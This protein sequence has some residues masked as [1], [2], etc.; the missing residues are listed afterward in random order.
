[1]LG[2]VCMAIQVTLQSCLFL[3]SAEHDYGSC[4][5]WKPLNRPTYQSADIN[6]DILECMYCIY[7]SVVYNNLH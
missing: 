1:M 2:T 3:N 7:A 5:I 6:Y 4:V